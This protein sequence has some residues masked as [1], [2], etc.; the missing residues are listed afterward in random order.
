MTRTTSA[1]VF[2]FVCY[3][4]LISGS[5]VEGRLTQ[6]E[7]ADPSQEVWV[8][9]VDLE[10][11]DLFRGPGDGPQPPAENGAFE[12][13]TKDTTGRS[14]GY[15]VRD[16]AGVV[17]SVKL[18]PEAQAEV[19]SSRLLWAIGFHQPP[20]YYV[21]AWTLTG[22]EAGPQAGGR[23]R[24]EIDQWNDVG[25]WRWDEFPHT[26]TAAYAGLLVAQ[27]FLNNW[28]LKNSNNKIIERAHPTAPRLYVVRDLGASL[29]SNEQAKWVRWTK[30]R[31]E[32]GT[33]NDVKGFEESGFID[34]VED[35]YVKFSYSG[36]NKPLVS[37]LT[38]AHVRWTSK[39]MSRLSD[40]Q[41][42]D[43]FRAGDYPPDDANRFIAKFKAKIA[44]GLALP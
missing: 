2:A 43:A 16:A 6:H 28:D 22:Q 25:E 29:G 5:P 10:S 12:F 19:V 4:L 37:R 8:D 39:L 21:N 18:G 33:K 3:S 23:F 30:L 41:W 31:F 38:P 9:P 42:Q 40:G 17:W 14:P 24:P 26:A 7:S 15:D 44:E 1:A 34:G 20:T 32:Q 36:P 11:R 13:V 35:G 27:M